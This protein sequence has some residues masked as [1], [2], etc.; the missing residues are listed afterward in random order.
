[1]RTKTRRKRDLR[2]EFAKAALTGLLSRSDVDHDWERED[3]V[4]TAFRYADVAV[5]R[6]VT[7]ECLDREFDEEDE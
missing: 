6:A 1:M 4:Q 5:S 3:L 2:I 7:E